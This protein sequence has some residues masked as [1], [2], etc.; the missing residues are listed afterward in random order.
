LHAERGI[1]FAIDDRV[2]AQV[3]RLETDRSL[4]AR[5]LRRAFERLVEGPLA[6]EIV[7]GRLHQG[8][9]LRIAC[10]AAGTLDIRSVA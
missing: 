2:I 10:N 8:A 7:A 4:G 6:N 5:P 9:R 3:L 1:A